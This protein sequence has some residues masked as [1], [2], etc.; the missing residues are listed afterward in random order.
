[1]HTYAPDRYEALGSP[2][3]VG[4]G[5]LASEPA[6]SVCGDLVSGNA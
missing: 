4:R 3:S 1:M 5:V 6:P 2:V